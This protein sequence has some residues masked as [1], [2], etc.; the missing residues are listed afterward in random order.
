MSFCLLWRP[1][2][3]DDC[4]WSRDL[5]VHVCVY[6]YECVYV[7]QLYVLYMYCIEGYYLMEYCYGGH[8]SFV[9]SI[10]GDLSSY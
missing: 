3:G 7:I 4:L 1:H 2:D 5:S 10:E 8:A 9:R 6:V